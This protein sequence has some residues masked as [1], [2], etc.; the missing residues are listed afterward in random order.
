M[1]F[2]NNHWQLWL[3]LIVMLVVI[4][5]NELMSQKKRGKE[6]T[7]AA[8]VALMNHDNAQVFDLRDAE[9]FRAGHIID[10]IHASVDD[11]TQGRMDKYKAKP[12]V[13]VCARGMHSAALAT[14]LR[15][16]G[17]AQPMVLAGGMTAWQTASMPLVKG[18]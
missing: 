9:A 14:K 12:V 16:Q 15:G 3:A 6:L 18:K 17:F 8:A 5:I 13:L 4:F 2:I 1:Q 11:F 7:P 10:S